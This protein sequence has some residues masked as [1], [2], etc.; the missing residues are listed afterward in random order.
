MNK[1]NLKYGLIA[2]AG[3]GISANVSAT[4]LTCSD[5]TFTPNAYV[6]Y[7]EIDKACLE[8]VDRDGGTYASSRPR[9]LHRL[10]AV[11]ISVSDMQTVTSDPAISPTCLKLSRPCLQASPSRLKISQSVRR[12]IFML[13]TSTGRCL[14]LK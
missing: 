2:L 6:A 5:L 4:D 1:M 9:L 12:S 8:V 3:L 14:L 13:V 10:V 7:G 11:H